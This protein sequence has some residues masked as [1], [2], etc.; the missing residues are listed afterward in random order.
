[1]LSAARQVGQLLC[2]GFDG[3]SA[4]PGLLAAIRDGEI[5][6]VV[7]MGRNV[8]G[9]AQVAS[10]TN[11]LRAAAPP[12]LPLLV[13]I[14]QEGGRV[15][16][17]RGTRWPA[18]AALG[19]GSPQTTEAVARA[20]GD[21]LAAVGVGL[22]FAP[23]LDVLTEP[24]SAV[25]GDRAF[26]SEPERVAAHG[27]AYA[28]GLRAAGVAACA[29]HF[30]GHGGIA[31]DSHVELPRDPAPR[32][33]IDSVYVM[34][35]ARAVAQGVE[36]IMTAHVAYEALEPGVPATLSRRAIT[37]V[38]RGQLGYEGVVVT[39]DLSMKAISERHA[40]DEA[41]GG[42]L[43]AGADLM[44]VCDGGEDRRAEA[45]AAIASL[46]D[47]DPYLQRVL[48]NSAARIAALKARLPAGPV[49]P[50]RAEAIVGCEAH[51]RLAAG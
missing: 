27:L 47:A 39:D 33:R 2:V 34:P 25:I 14:D 38:L 48:A 3:T 15:Q 13:A 20:I 19:K 10:L 23:V 11:T 12:D 18:G 6:A 49:D 5:G 50:A 16:R 31:A 42:A 45:F 17:L 22:D 35:F 51:R 7:L 26:G 4:P 32:E 21:E 46:Q 41:I 8:E 1:M 37:E 40:L 28:R 44:L 9:A 24:A 30:P 43:A 36:S 29:K